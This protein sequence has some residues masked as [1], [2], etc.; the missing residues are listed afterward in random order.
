MRPGRKNRTTK[1]LGL[2][3]VI[4]V[5]A[6]ASYAFTATNTVAA[7]KAGDGAAAITGYNVT[8]VTYTQNPLD[9]TLL[10]TYTFTLDGAAGS[11]KA[12]TVSTQLG[13]DTC[14]GGLLNSWTCTPPAGTTVQSL[15]N[16]R[17]I[18]VQ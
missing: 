4:G 17:V 7:S 1:T 2:V 15:D 3:L 9:P 11:V 16:L 12:R 14:V 5:V 18:A 6:A 10:A 8:G 13:Y